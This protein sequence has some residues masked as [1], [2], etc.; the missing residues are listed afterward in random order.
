MSQKNLSRRSFI[1]L[2][3]AAAAILGIPGCVTRPVTAPE[4]VAPG[5]KIRIAQIGFGG[6]GNTDI[7]KFA[8]EEVVALCDIDWTLPKVK[9]IFELYPNAKRYRDFRV[10]LKEM[11]Q[12]I[13]AV[14]ISTPDH[15]HF[16]C[17]YMAI[18]MGKH[19]YVQKPLTPTI[20]EARELLR[21]SREMKVCTQMGNQGHSGEGTRMA[22]EWYRAGLLGNVSEVHAWT[23]RPIWPQGM[24][25]W[26]AEEPLTEGL[27]WDLFLGRAQ[28]RPFSKLIH[29]FKWRGF[30]DY[31]SGAMGDMG[32]HILDASYWAME[33]EAPISVEAESTGLTN[34]A[35]PKNAK[36]T[37]QF[38]ARGNR[39]AVKLI[40]YEG[41]LKPEMP[42]SLKAEGHVFPK[43]GQLW[44][45]DKEMLLDETDYCLS[46]RIAPDAR[47]Q[48]LRPN[49][50]AKTIPRVPKGNHYENWLS[51]IR[52]GN[53]ELAVSRFDY[54]VPLT[55]FLLLGNI[56]LLTG[57][58]L[59]WNRDQMTTGDA[60]ADS[61]I[62]PLF[63]KGW[64]L[65]ET[66]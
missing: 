38:P 42:A 23:N 43:G 30:R 44:L 25:E 5:K 60:E 2:S 22:C 61:Y 35:F 9:E 17:A 12:E 20:W 31:G 27:N 59:T 8:N 49:L 66:V 18:S 50:P 7:R 45:G 48:A 10:M 21:L 3:A 11:R 13:D 28:V 16:L 15:M 47:M 26:P 57:K 14:V 46:P 1:T 64:T 51:A 62:K 56:A 63:R 37:Y 65:A 39:P 33:L 54:A 55:E 41:G 40:W 32:C 36:V 6:Q 19:V 53:P 52:A 58:K 24:P 4:P 29:P 34:V